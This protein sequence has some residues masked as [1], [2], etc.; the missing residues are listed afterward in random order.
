LE[1]ERP[2]AEPRLPR[3]AVDLD[4][5]ERDR[6]VFEVDRVRDQAPG[7]RRDLLKAEV[8][9]AAD[10]DLVAVREGPEPAVELLDVGRVAVVGD[11]P[12]VDEEVA[13][14]DY[15]PVV[16]SVGVADTN[17]SHGGT[18]PRGSPVTRSGAP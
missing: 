11:V 15:R 6:R 10:D 5:V 1:V 17:D 18:E 8:V 13:V 14:R 12:R 16:P 2:P 4:A 7:P 3:A 9:I